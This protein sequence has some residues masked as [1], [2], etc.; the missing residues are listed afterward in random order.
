MAQTNL[1]RAYVAQPNVVVKAHATGNDFVM[2]FDPDGSRDCDEAQVRFLCDRH[3]G[4]GGDGVIRITHPEFVSDVSDEVAQ[5]LRSQ[6]AQ[7]FMDYRNA[8]GSIAQMCGNG[9]RATALVIQALS[10]M[11]QNVGSELA[12]GTRVGVKTLV[13]KGDMPAYGSDVFTVDLGRY[14][15]GE[16]GA[17]EVSAA[18]D[19]RGAGTYVDMGNPHVVVLDY[20][21]EGAP[22]AEMDLTQKPQVTPVIEQGQNVE[23]VDIVSVS[24]SS[25]EGTSDGAEKRDTETHCIETR[26]T[27]RMRVHERGV[28]ETLSCGTGLG[29]SGVVLRSRTGVGAWDITVAGGTLG[30][31]VD[32]TNVRL[33]G[34][35]TIVGVITLY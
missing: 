35:A 33:T 22:L 34:P 19:V 31:D 23:F 12:L 17:Y 15:L 21:R 10:L 28:G 13:Y 7:W 3:R 16:Q 27:A 14:Q 25:S 9:T 20:D 29:A 6:G 11:E 2:I 30:V 4:I 1:D 24:D 8:D 32:D 18:P 5:S 26:G